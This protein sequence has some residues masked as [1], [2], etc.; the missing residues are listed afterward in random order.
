[1]AHSVPAIET[2]RLILPSGI[3]LEVCRI[4]AG[5]FWMG[6]RERVP[7][8]WD[9]PAPPHQ[10]C[11][12]DDFWLGQTPVTLAQFRMFVHATGSKWKTTSVTADAQPVVNVSWHEALAFCDWLNSCRNSLP[13]TAQVRWPAELADC[14]A[15]LPTEAEWERACRGASGDSCVEQ[16]FGCGDG[17]EALAAVAWFGRDW[18]AGIPRVQQKRP[19]DWGLY[20]LHGL[21]WEWCHDEYSPT[22]YAERA[23]LTFEP[24]AA[25]RLDPEQSI[26]DVLRVV[27][28]GS[29]GNRVGYCR[30]ADRGRYRPEG[31][32]A[33][34]GFRVCLF[35]GPCRAQVTVDQAQAELGLGHAARRQAD[36]EWVRQGGAGSAAGPPRVGPSDKLASAGR[37]R[38]GFSLPHRGPVWGR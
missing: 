27:R 23:M 21:V 16:A 18:N 9:T 28:G 14:V 10:V 20:D 29:W 37:T 26:N 19:T 32:S 22:A 24:G 1:V 6:S 34:L 11:I 5:T 8:H 4:P 35:P 36:A 38:S 30:A 3:P 17:A 12:K 31:R 33:Y 13:E 2:T 15:T 7:D 25:P